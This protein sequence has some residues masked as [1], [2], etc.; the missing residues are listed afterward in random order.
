MIL[1]LDADDVD[2]DVEVDVDLDSDVVV[3]SAGVSEE[4]AVSD[5][6]EFESPSSSNWVLYEESDPL[7]ILKAYV[8]AS[9]PLRVKVKLSPVALVVSSFS[10]LRLSESPVIRAMV[11]PSSQPW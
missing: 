9:R 2:D 1:E 3:D 8:P 6:E 4:A 5:S 10:T 11:Q 7:V